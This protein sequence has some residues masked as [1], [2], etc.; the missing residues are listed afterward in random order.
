MQE[1]TFK[2]VVFDLLS[3]SLNESQ[4]NWSTIDRKCFAIFFCLKH[5]EKFMGTNL[6]I[7]IR[8][9]HLP[10]KNFITSGS[11]SP[12]GKSSRCLV[13]MQKFDIEITYIPGNSNSFANVLSRP[14]V[15][16]LL[17][18]D[19]EGPQTKYSRFTK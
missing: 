15:V 5:M 2:P 7:L 10:L 1:Y 4:K 14:N 12:K 17:K 18:T 16:Q 19:T 8:T 6:K 9:N 11:K 3:K 13:F